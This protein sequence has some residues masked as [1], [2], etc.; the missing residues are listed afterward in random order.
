MK[1]NIIS[2]IILLLVTVN[3]YGQ[4][5]GATVDI[6]LES[7]SFNKTHPYYEYFK[8]KDDDYIK[9][10][11]FGC[12][13]NPSGSI[14]SKEISSKGKN[15]SGLLIFKI[16]KQGNSRYDT[17]RNCVHPSAYE[18]ERDPGW[19]S[20]VPIHGKLPNGVWSTLDNDPKGNTGVTLHVKETPVNAKLE[21]VTEEGE[22]VRTLVDNYLE[23]GT[24]D[25][26]WNPNSVK[27]GSY[28]LHSA[29]D[30][31]FMIQRIHVQS[32]WLREVFPFLFGEQIAYKKYRKSESSGKL[33]KGT[34][35]SINHDRHGVTLGLTNIK[36]TQVRIALL[37]PDGSLF[38][39][40]VNS[41][42]KENIYEGLLNEHVKKTGNYL[43]VVEVN[44]ATRTQKIKLKKQA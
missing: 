31:Q 12:V 20:I 4:S 43:L 1:T 36:N 38:K 17:I 21:I 27:P 11:Y 41:K 6:E 9:W 26:S 14:F 29:I 22:S 34:V 28:L 32:S 7:N 10:L 19:E 13:S 18:I 15:E 16:T 42:L 33:P 30:G 37:K 44:G 40:I 23:K 8:N 39:T 25:F 3:F 5:D 35:L 2:S 24:Y